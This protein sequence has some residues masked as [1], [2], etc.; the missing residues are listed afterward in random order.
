[1]W[2]Q[3]TLRKICAALLCSIVIICA[4]CAAQ[5]HTPF[6]VR[7]DRQ[8]MLT[9]GAL[10]HPV[11][12]FA[13]DRA[14]L[15]TAAQ[16]ALL[17]NI[18]WLRA[19]TDRTVSLIGHA[20]EIGTDAYNLE[21]GDRRARAVAACLRTDGIVD[22]QIGLITSRGKLEP[23]TADHTSAARAKNRRVEWQVW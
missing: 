2:K 19:R 18:Q 10:P 7:P 8:R 4:A 16:R 13:F 15:S 17:E 22:A 5:P 21:L 1:M 12:Y 3:M 9:E 11:I 20:D 23:A 14:N 6:A